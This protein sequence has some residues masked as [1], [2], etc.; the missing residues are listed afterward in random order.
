MAFETAFAACFFAGAGAGLRAGV[1]ALTGVAR[2]TGAAFF[3]TTLFFGG[4]FFAGR[5]GFAGFADFFV[6]LLV[7]AAATAF[8][9]LR[10]GAFFAGERLTIGL[11]RAD[12]PV[13]VRLFAEDV[14]AVRRE[15]RLEGVLFTPLIVGSL[16]RSS[17]LSK[18]AAQKAFELPCNLRAA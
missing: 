18:K 14:V 2:L 7:E 4:V 16:M 10:A 17:Q 8:V 11:G 15:A 5:A 13:N 6:L 9:A 12:L 1:F 3:G